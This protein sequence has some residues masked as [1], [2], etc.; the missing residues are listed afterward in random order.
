MDNDHDRPP[1]ECIGSFLAYEPDGS[2]HTIEIW[3]RFESVHDRARQ[4]VHPGLIV[5]TTTEGRGVTRIARGDYRLTDQPEVRLTSSDA[6][7]P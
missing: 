5:L 6:N 1:L 4:R 2:R 7:A 3:T